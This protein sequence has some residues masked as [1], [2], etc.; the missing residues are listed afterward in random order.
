M[1]GD[2]A[3]PTH[4][5][6][7]VEDR[8][9]A[10]LMPIATPDQ[11][12]DRQDALTNL[13]V[14]S[15]KEGTDY[16]KIPGTD[17]KNNLLKPGAERLCVAFGLTSEPQI[18]EQEIDHDRPVN[19]SLA[20]WVSVSKPT[21][22]EQNEKKAKGLGRLKKYGSK[23]TWQEKIDESGVSYGVYRYVV[24][25]VLKD[26]T[27]R[28]VGFG[29][30]SCS[31]YEAKYIR[32]PRDAENTVLKMAK[33]RAFVDATLTT[34]GL[35]DR[36]TQDVEDIDENK[37]V[38]RVEGEEVIEAELVV[39]PVENWMTLE[40]QLTAQEGEEGATYF[41]N[42]GGTK[43]QFKDLTDACGALHPAKVFLQARKLLIMDPVEVVRLVAPDYGNYDAPKVES[44]QAA[45]SSEGQAAAGSSA[46][47]SD[48]LPLD[49]DSTVVPPTASQNSSASQT[50]G[51]PAYEFDPFADGF[52]YAD[53]F[54]DKLCPAIDWPLFG[55]SPEACSVAYRDILGRSIPDATALTDDDYIT[56]HSAGRAF[57]QGDADEPGAFKLF[58]KT[59]G[60]GSNV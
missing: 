13:I 43:A 1:A 54:R 16:G 30:G 39:E 36:F 58:R 7:V 32:N 14:K 40:R 35:S 25:C 29:V 38:Y 52:S 47:E 41:K 19:Y 59:R 27:D 24:K 60:E 9:P 11:L 34:L 28:I 12:I 53:D 20:K 10:L 48:T 46:K 18:V 57:Y 8:K 6:A 55:D 3:N 56:L 49:T 15:L 17:D 5:L 51:K 26:S 4:E 31:T 2:P 23:F 37:E 45:T 21:E 22:A 33:K 50:T 42:I 44:D